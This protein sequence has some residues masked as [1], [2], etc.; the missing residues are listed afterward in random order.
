MSGPI[1]DILDEIAA[2]RHRQDKKWGEQ[3]HPSKRYESNS[4]YF[5][6]DEELAKSVTDERFKNGSG[7]WADILVEEVSEALDAKDE[8]HRREE[9]VQCAAV[10]AAWIEAIDRGTTI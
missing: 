3:N 8:S 4:A 1:W 10:C 2:E 9:L 6:P 5:M 7:S